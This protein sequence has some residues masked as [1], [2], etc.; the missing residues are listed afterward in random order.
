[1]KIGRYICIFSVCSCS[2]FSVFSSMKQKRKKKMAKSLFTYFRSWAAAAAAAEPKIK[3]NILH[4]L[5]LIERQGNLFDLWLCFLL[6]SL[7]LYLSLFLSCFMSLTY[8]CCFAAVLIFSNPSHISW[9]S[10]NVLIIYPQAHAHAPARPA[11]FFC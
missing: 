8:S 2:E 3:D 7:L 10:S 1:M 6:H 5:L 4:H 11:Q 9:N